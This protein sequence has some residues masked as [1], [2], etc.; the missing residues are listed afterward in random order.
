[1]ATDAKKVVSVRVKNESLEKL[2]EMA[3]Q[4]G[5]GVTVSPLINCAVELF[6]S[7]K[8]LFEGNGIFLQQSDLTDMLPVMEAIGE[9]VSLK[10]FLDII[11]AKKDKDG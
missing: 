5:N 8:D 2:E 11:D 1:M 7:E 9:P 6:L 3:L 10:L 4:Q